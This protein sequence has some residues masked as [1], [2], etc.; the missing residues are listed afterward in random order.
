MTES[1]SSLSLSTSPTSIR[2]SCQNVDFET[3]QTIKDNLIMCSG[4]DDCNLAK[5]NHHVEINNYS[6][7]YGWSRAKPY[8]GY[9]ITNHPST[10]KDGQQQ[11]YQSSNSTN[12]KSN[13]KTSHMFKKSNYRTDNST[14]E[15]VYHVNID[16]VTYKYRYKSHQ[17]PNHSLNKYKPILVDQNHQDNFNQS[18]QQIQQQTQ[19]LPKSQSQQDTYSDHQDCN[20]DNGLKNKTNLMTVIIFISII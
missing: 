9:I 18:D 12:T 11:S 3:V 6:M 20:H 4:E 5:Y 14:P 2:S 10:D 16:P 13:K 15:L 17:D 8:A 19:P 1:T 7:C